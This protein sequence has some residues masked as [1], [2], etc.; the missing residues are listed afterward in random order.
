MRLDRREFIRLAGTAAATYVLGRTAYAGTRTTGPRGQLRHCW[1]ELVELE[2]K[3]AKGQLTDRDMAKPFELIT[4]HSKALSTLVAMGEVDTD[5]AQLIHAAYRRSACQ[6]DGMPGPCPQPRDESVMCY[7]VLRL[8]QPPWVEAR[9]Y[10]AEKMVQLTRQAE[11]LADEAWLWPLDPG[12]V[13]RA[14][15]NVEREIREL[16]REP[17]ADEA[18]RFLTE[19]L[20]EH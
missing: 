19:I 4:V 9:E 1:I 12:I 8:R 7:S 17:E 10:I 5:V 16:S 20:L 14:Q 6:L 15:A 18:V 11:I 3:Q 2:E 13:A